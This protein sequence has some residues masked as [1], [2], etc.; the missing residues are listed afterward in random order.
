[1]KNKEKE[2]K[3]YNVLHISGYDRGVDEE[4]IDF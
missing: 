4:G 2:Y 1:M 3:F